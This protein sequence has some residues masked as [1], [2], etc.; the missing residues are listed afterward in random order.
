MLT[1]VIRCFITI[2]RSLIISLFLTT[3]VMRQVSR[4][5]LVINSL[6]FNVEES[7][8]YKNAAS[9]VLTHLRYRLFLCHRTDD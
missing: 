9:C 1:I 4:Q 2:L 3:L 6:V 5:V 7:E 8:T